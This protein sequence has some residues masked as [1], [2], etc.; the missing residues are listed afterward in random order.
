[1]VVIDLTQCKLK[2]LDYNPTTA[3]QTT[4]PS[5][6]IWGP[7]TTHP[8][9]LYFGPVYFGARVCGRRDLASEHGPRVVGSALIPIAGYIS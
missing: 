5:Q 1:M 7:R 3:T 9:A 2:Q 8:I 4:R 6:L